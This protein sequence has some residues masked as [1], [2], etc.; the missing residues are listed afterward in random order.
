MTVGQSQSPL[1]ELER[2]CPAGARPGTEEDILEGAVPDL[3]AYATSTCEVA[4]AV[5]VAQRHG[6]ALVARGAGT[7]QDWGAAPEKVGLVLDLSKLAGVV[8]HVSGDL[9]VTV[10]AGTTL[11]ELSRTLSDAGQRLP[12]DE[13]VPG[14]TA[15]GVVATGA[16]G[17]LRY[18]HGSVR[19][20][21]LGLT[22]VRADGTVARAGS[23][24]VKNV[25]GYD[26][27]KLF[28]GS[29]G[30]LGI[31]TELTFKLRPLPA[32]SLFVSATYTN[33]AE[34][35]GGLERL[36]RS[37]AAP[38]AIELD[39]PGPGAPME[40]C[41]LT[42]GRPGP[43]EARA[44]QLAR[45]LPGAS[46]SDSAP[47]WW[48]SLPGPVTFKLTSAIS[49]VLPLAERVGKACAGLGLSARLSGSAGAGVVFLGLPAET[50]REKLRA[51]LQELRSAVSQA[52]GYATVLRAPAPSK[53]GLDV[54]GPVPGLELMRRVKHS[55]D[56]G[57][58]LAPGRFVGGI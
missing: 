37:Q 53:A 29:Y 31:M 22:V 34:A 43:T 17:P 1:A 28:T 33:P 4:A 11:G 18:G 20:L 35:A 36:V 51:L 32:S 10:K 41:V 49:G 13:V 7:K 42:E 19:D 21:L 6:L 44:G 12:L 52:E 2:A 25:A 3:V 57:R 9:V 40:L 55:F 50:A 48:G 58:L 16:S 24:V 45:L 14:S 30:T 39:R 54:W 46:V 27:P 23:K 26:L 5:K 8:E 15:G 56:P 47:A 38:A